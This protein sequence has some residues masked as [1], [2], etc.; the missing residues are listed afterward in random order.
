MPR[1]P[2]LPRQPRQPREPRRPRCDSE[3]EAN[4]VLPEFTGFLKLAC[5]RPAGHRGKH[6]DYLLG[7]DF[8]ATWSSTAI[9]V[10]FDSSINSEVLT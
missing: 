8:W 3:A 2:R 10:S 6:V 9:T 4:V 5:A 1:L 7:R